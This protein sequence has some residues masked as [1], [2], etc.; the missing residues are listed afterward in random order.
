M[1]AG[2]ERLSLDGRVMI[3]TGGAS[4]L[5]RATGTLCAARGASVVLADLDEKA[6]AAVVEEIAGA[7]GKAA[8]VRTDVTSESDVE[9]MVAFALSTFG[10]LHAAFNNAGIDNGHKPV[11]D[12]PLNEW[13]RNID[14]N[15]TG[16]F[17]CLKHEVEHMR[18]HGGG[19]IVTTSSTAGGVGIAN[20]ASYVSAKHGVVGVTRATALD[21]ASAGIR[22]NTILPG[23]IETPMLEGALKDP[24]VRALV[25]REHPLGRAGKPYE[26]AETVAF[27]VSDAAS[28][29]TGACIMVDGGFT[30]K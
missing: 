5:G 19:A 6:G 13:Q 16:I 17:L 18:R 4:G 30:A 3:V 2:Y 27:L 28:F 21:Y 25:E 14:V 24:G 29:I 12:L 26:I 23:G 15:L 20:A 8:F 1:A 9:A 11:G 7:G 10:G 22:V